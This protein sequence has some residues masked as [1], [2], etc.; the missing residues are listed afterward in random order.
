MNFYE[1]W[2]YRHILNTLW[3]T[4]TLVVLIFGVNFLMPLI[5]WLLLSGKKLS[6]KPFKKQSGT[7]TK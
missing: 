3:F 7:K 2:V 6:W 5:L 4:W 1:S